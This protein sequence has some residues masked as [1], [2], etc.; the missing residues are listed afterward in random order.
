M[1]C[2]PQKMC[3]EIRE[4]AC[5][6]IIGKCINIKTVVR[7]GSIKD[8]KYRNELVWIDPHQHFCVI[9]LP[10]EPIIGYNIVRIKSM[11]SNICG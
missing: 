9:T 10:G 4:G 1:L 11:A 8:L 6:Q 3:F 2:D 7:R 5:L